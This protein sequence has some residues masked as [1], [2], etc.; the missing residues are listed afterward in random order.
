MTQQPRPDDLADLRAELDTQRAEF[1][2][3]RARIERRERRRHFPRRLLPLTL[4]ALL[5]A[6][7]PLSILAAAPFF[8][9]L[10]A[11]AAVHR[12]NIQAI[13]NAGITTGFED[14]NDPTTR[15]YDP[16]GS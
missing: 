13:G 2:A 10:P 11:A 15:L 1:A 4:V 12:P 8:S 7:M 3:F 6:L 16:K 5:V 14:P 9:D